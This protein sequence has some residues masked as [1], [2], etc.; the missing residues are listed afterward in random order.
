M[1]H[2]KPFRTPQGEIL[3]IR[4]EPPFLVNKLSPP[5]V[6][7]ARVVIM[8]EPG[9]ETQVD[10]GTVQWSAISKAAST[11]AGGFRDDARL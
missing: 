1:I 11:A 4:T 2:W 7:Q 8:T 3:T 10:Y 6:P 9:E 5:R